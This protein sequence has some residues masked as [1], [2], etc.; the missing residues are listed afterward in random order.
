MVIIV[1][2]ERNGSYISSTGKLPKEWQIDGIAGELMDKLDENILGILR[3]NARLSVSAIA[4]QLA[5]SRSTVQDRIRRMEENGTIRGYC[6]DLSSSAENSRIRAFVTVSIEPQKSPV[7]IAELKTIRQVSSIH[8]VS[9]KFDLVIEMA[10]SDTAEMDVLLDRL[11]EIPGVIRTE[12]SIV[13]TTK[14]Q[15]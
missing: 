12:T 15:R 13:L 8:T 10:T 1:A 2:T 14:L 7:I 4:D 11:T 6:V 9:G 3:L 5:S